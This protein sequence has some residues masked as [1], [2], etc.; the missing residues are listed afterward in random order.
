MGDPR[1]EESYEASGLSESYRHQ[2][3]ALDFMLQREVGPI[4]SE[5]SLWAPDTSIP[6]N[7]DGEQG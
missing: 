6:N 5:F 7:N 3:T 2:K 4:E 1:G